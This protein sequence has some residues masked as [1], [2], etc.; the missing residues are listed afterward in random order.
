MVSI[1]EATANAI[2]FAR[3]AL[4]PERTKD[5]RVEEIES[6][7]VA[8]RITLSMTAPPVDV[9]TLSDLASLFNTRR[10]YKVFTVSKES[11]EVES[12]KIREL[13]A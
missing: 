2:A 1:Q 6:A 8:W 4:G 7:T 11:G 9:P 3:E 13:T 10:E 5:I 12:M